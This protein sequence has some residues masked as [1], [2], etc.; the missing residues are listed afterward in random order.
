M[1]NPPV[2]AEMLLRAMLP[3]ASVEAVTG[4]LLEEY[5]DRRAPAVGGV[6]AD[7]WYVRQVA[8][9][10]MHAYR[11]F[12]VPLIFWM[13][14]HDLFNTF[15]DAA[16]ASYADGPP[17]MP[18]V[19]VAVLLAAAVYGTWRTG[20]WVGGVVATLGL[21]GVTWLFMVVWWMGTLYPFAQVQQTN[22]YWIQAWQWSTSRDHTHESFL[23]WLFWDNVG[24]LMFFGLAGGALSTVCGVVGSTAY[25]WYR[26]GFKFQF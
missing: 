8:D 15:R 11:W 2:V 14:S 23:R 1:K 6:R 12:A 5:R 21:F 17:V 19:G 13:V 16:G 25:V 3:P 10:F 24:G 4:D 7:F 9:V 20:R 26:K 22:P 18:F